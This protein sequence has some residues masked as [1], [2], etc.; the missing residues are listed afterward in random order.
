MIAEVNC[1]KNSIQNLSRI[2]IRILLILWIE[3]WTYK[4]RFIV[5]KAKKKHSITSVLSTTQYCEQNSA[6]IRKVARLVKKQMTIELFKN[7]SRKRSLLQ[8]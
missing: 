1:L 7:V 8:L 4:K 2:P 5:K 6:E 3:F